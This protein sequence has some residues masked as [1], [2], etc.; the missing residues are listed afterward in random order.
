MSD[1]L[2]ELCMKLVRADHEDEVIK[3]LKNVGYWEDP[4]VWR[5]FDDNANNYSVIGAQQAEAVPALIEKIV[6]SADAYLVNECLV[7]GIDP[8]GKDAPPTMRY[9]VAQFVE[10]SQHPEWETNGR[11]ENWT[12]EERR[13]A[14][15]KIT[16]ATTGDNRDPCIT[17][18]DEGE[19]QVPDKV[20]NT[21]MSLNKTNKFNIPFVQGKF[22]MGGTGVFRFCGKRHLQ[23]VLTRRNPALVNGNNEDDKLWSFTVVR[24]DDPQENER[25]SVYRYLA[26]LQADENTSGEVLRFPA[27]KLNIKP[28]KNV[29]YKNP[30]EFGSLIK[31][32]NYQYKN[33]SHI[34][35]SRGLL[36]PLDVRLPNFALPFMLHEC[37]KYSSDRGFDLPCTGL[38]VRLDSDQ[39]DNLEEGFPVTESFGVRGQKMNVRFYGFKKGKAESYLNNSEGVIFTINGQTHGVL[40]SRFFTHKEIKFDKISKSLLACVDCSKLDGRAIEELFMNTRES[41]AE[42]EFRD[43]LE[44]KLKQIT[45]DNKAL[46]AFCNR[47]R[48]EDI[49]EKISND[50]SLEDILKKVMKTTPTLSRLFLK[51]E[52]M[53][54]PFDIKKVGTQENADLKEFPTFFRFKGMKDG[55]ILK[56]TVQKNRGARISFD[57]DV[58]NKYFERPKDPGEYILDCHD[59]LGNRFEIEDDHSLNLHNG[60]ATL[61]VDIPDHFNVGD[62]VKITLTVKDIKR[63]DT[64]P[65]FNTAELELT[66]FVKQEKSLGNGRSKPP[67]TKDGKD[68]DAA[69]NLAIPEAHWVNQEEWEKYEEFTFTENSALYALPIP[70]E[71]ESKQAYEFYINADNIHLLHEL[72]YCNGDE[73]IIKEQFKVGMALVAL[74]VI[75]SCDDEEDGETVR[76]KVSQSCDAIA[77]I[78]IP[79]MNVLSDLDVT[80]IS[81]ET[82]DQLVDPLT[83]KQG[84][85][86]GEAMPL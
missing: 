30:I 38:F 1:N 37:R 32:Y 41:L 55:T 53:S 40:P 45:R 61:N 20:S 75:H 58:R 50:K 24:R 79:L 9:A 44:K 19:G 28:E 65:F 35:L 36:R 34:L 10:K 17:I 49:R 13:A 16:L 59:V 74:S 57:T 52:R 8:E 12:R 71:D 60:I 2:E 83:P 29:A 46:R 84:S 42:S 6:N 18:V 56:R 64:D 25:S 3:I 62:I 67:S 47:R 4:K 69:S 78:L 73:R 39:S 86:I 77:M 68:R 76:E 85:L 51:G 72:K 63:L 7:S 22:N 21:F 82:E 70:S 15:Q 33:Q 23:L 43:K 27:E 11:I 81:E 26:P 31:L 66:P 54:S 80:S 48:E 14:A 5:D